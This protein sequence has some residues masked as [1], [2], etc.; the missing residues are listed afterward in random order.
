VALFSLGALA[1]SSCDPYELSTEGA[2]VLH[3][4]GVAVSVASSVLENESPNAS[5]P[6][7]CGADY[8]RLTARVTARPVGVK[9]VFVG[10]GPAGA[11]GR[12]LRPARYDS[13]PEL[14]G[15]SSPRNRR[16]GG[17]AKVLE[18]PATQT[19][20]LAHA[21]SERDGAARLTYAWQQSYAARVPT[22]FLLVLM[23]ADG[24]RPVKVEVT[25][26]LEV[27]GPLV[28]PFALALVGGLA[29]LVGGIVLAVRKPKRQAGAVRT[30]HE[31]PPRR[32]P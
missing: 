9:P 31:T 15:L 19:F 32:R 16:A 10:I 13:T 7:F 20:W 8:D 23:N 17:A 22:A 28:W 2:G 4:R 25:R 12:Y 6:S 11:V 18:P 27:P 29:L 24:S 26:R 5:F 3:S 14:V 1:V 30:S 21:R